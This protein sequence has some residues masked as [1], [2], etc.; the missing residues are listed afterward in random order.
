M[1]TTR[2]R[3]RQ[4][5]F[6]L[7]NGTLGGTQIFCT[8]L[9][10]CM[11]R[12]N[13]DARVIF[14]ETPGEVAARLERAEVPYSWLGLKRGSHVLYHPKRIARAVRSSGRDGVLLPSSGYLAAALRTGGYQGRIVS[15]EH[16]G[17]LQLPEYSTGR[18][19][20][21]NVRWLSALI[22]R[23][24]ALSGIWANDAQ[25]A[26]SD[27][28]LRELM[29]RRHAD[30]VVRIYN[31]VD[32]ARFTPAE[33]PDHMSR[34]REATVF[35]SVSRLHPGKGFDV[36]LEALAKI[37]GS[38]KVGLQ[39]VGWG[40]ARSSLER[41]AH[42]LGVA[43]VVEFHGPTNDPA[44]IWQSCDVAVVPSNTWVEAF[45]GVAT[46]AMACGKPVVATRNGGLSEVV[47]HGVTGLLVEPGNED[48]LAKALVRYQQDPELRRKHGRAGRERCERL[49]D[50]SHCAAAY[51]AL[52]Q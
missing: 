9:A 51:A 36:L 47:A 4:L 22:R 37:A 6:V 45:G 48:E 40:D 26:V 50:I 41:L 17:H 23:L 31:G 38:H 33:V 21:R 5:A 10:A 15:V 2:A 30:K 14:I 39:I 25:V 52:F 32:L 46:E 43:D 11:R 8:D 28:V 27:F 19:L 34:D 1:Q 49:F 3:A 29:C 16:G 13:I 24:D 44:A 20:V 12:Q 7:W 42:R 35:A 18:R